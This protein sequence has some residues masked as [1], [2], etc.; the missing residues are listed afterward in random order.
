MFVFTDQLAQL[1]VEV[2]VRIQSYRLGSMVS[3]GHTWTTQMSQF[4]VSQEMLCLFFPI[5]E[6]KKIL[7]AVS[8]LCTFKPQL[9]KYQSLK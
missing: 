8:S 2:L 5:Q 4:K 9:P 3:A 1:S 7:L 6:K